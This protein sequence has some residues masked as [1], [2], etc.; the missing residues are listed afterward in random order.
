MV[1][2][3]EMTSAHLEILASLPRTFS[4]KHPIAQELVSVGFAIKEELG[5]YST[6][7]RTIAGRDYLNHV[8]DNGD[9]T[10]TQ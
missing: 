4:P 7:K 9:K 8:F 10:F 6:F 5:K 1:P 3:V 2:T